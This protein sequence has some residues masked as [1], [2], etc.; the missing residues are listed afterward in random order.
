MDP[1]PS[2]SAQPAALHR[3]FA[4]APPRVSVRRMSTPDGTPPVR[5]NTGATGP[6]GSSD[7][8]RRLNEYFEAGGAPSTV[9]AS[10]GGT[11][12]D[13]TG[14]GV[15]LAAFAAAARGSAAGTPAHISRAGRPGEAA[16]AATPS[17]LSEL[18]GRELDELVDRIVDRIE[19]RVVD[20]LE[21]RGR[22]FEGGAY[23]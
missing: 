17:S 13:S 5:R 1:E 6:T 8:I 2:G 11:F 7:L 21:R 4:V 14:N 20:E 18:S 23:L 19:Q 9:P 22:R 16:M 12:G 15:S 10:R 3:A